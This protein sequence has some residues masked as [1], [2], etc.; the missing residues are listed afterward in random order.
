VDIE[1]IDILNLFK[2]MDL[3]GNGQI[4]FNE[5]LRTIVGEMN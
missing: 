1:E 4:D 3:D 2:T 5:F